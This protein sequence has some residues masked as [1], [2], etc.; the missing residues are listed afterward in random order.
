MRTGN[1]IACEHQATT[2]RENAFT[3]AIGMYGGHPY[4]GNCAKCLSSGENNKEHV[5]E[6]TARL[7]RT[8]PSDKPLISGCCD[9]AKNPAKRD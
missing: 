6:L 5:Q 9:S 2:A 4:L 7:S 3:C 8:H 1:Q